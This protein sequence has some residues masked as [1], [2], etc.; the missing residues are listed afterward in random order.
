[1]NANPSSENIYLSVTQVAERFG[2]S[3]DSIWRWKRKGEF[4][5][6]VRIGANC[7]RWRLSDIVDH[8]SS[9]VAAFATSYSWSRAAW[10]KISG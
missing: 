1:M 3:T 5:A 10:T 6:A 4:P 7:T 9:F 8:E 2:V